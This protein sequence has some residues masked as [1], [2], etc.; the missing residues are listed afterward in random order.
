M[1]FLRP[2][3]R[4]AS[5]GSRRRAPIG[6]AFA[7][8]TTQFRPRRVFVCAVRGVNESTLSNAPACCK[9]AQARIFRDGVGGRSGGRLSHVLD[10][11]RTAATRCRTKAGAT[12][13]STAAATTGTTMP[14]ITNSAGADRGA[15]PGAGAVAPGHGRRLR[16]GLHWCGDC[17]TIRPRHDDAAPTPVPARR[18]TA[19]SRRRPPPPHRPPPAPRPMNRPPHPRPRRAAVGLPAA[20]LFV[21]SVALAASGVALAPALPLTRARPV[22]RGSRRLGAPAGSRPAPRRTGRLPAGHGQRR[23]DGAGVLRPGH[24]AGLG[25][26]FRRGGARIPRGVAA[27]SLV[28]SCAPGAKRW[29]SARASTTT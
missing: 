26:Q 22:P 16:R 11:R 23:R 3:R 7:P 18:L 6:S 10:I 15:G 27:R 24:G 29:R 9:N 28:R 13:R 12:V 1:G 5:A 2:S 21:G 25:I 17:A 4:A 19:T 8:G 20:L 14:A